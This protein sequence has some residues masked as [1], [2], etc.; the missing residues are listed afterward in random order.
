MTQQ[1]YIVI[2]MSLYIET[3]TAWNNHSPFKFTPPVRTEKYL[4]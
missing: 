4:N 3:T 1:Q 2:K